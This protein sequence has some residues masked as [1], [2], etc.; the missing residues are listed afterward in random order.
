[1]P[2]N[3]FVV[4]EPPPAPEVTGAQLDP[5]VT[6]VRVVLPEMP[7]KLASISDVPAVTPLTNPLPSTVALVGVPEVQ[8]TP[9]V[10]SSVL[11][12]E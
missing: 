9:E 4:P 5:S 8:A 11:P 7:L 3:A 10:M 12:S 2:I 1:M 6:T